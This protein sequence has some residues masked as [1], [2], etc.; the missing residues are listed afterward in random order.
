MKQSATTLLDRPKQRP[1]SR[2]RRVSP[3]AFVRLLV[4]RRSLVRADDPAAGLLGLLDVKT[5]VT[6]FIREENL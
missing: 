2:S 1:K 6:Y 5:G 4:S 3:E